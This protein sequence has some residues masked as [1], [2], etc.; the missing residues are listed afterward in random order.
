[1]STKGERKMLSKEDIRGILEKKRRAG[2]KATRDAESTEFNQ[3]EPCPKQHPPTGIKPS[4]PSSSVP[5]KKTEDS[6]SMDTVTAMFKMVQEM[7]SQTLL[8]QTIINE[9][10]DEKEKSL[11]NQKG[12]TEQNGELHYL[13]QH[14]APMESSKGQLRSKLLS[15]YDLPEAWPAYEW[16]KEWAGAQQ[17]VGALLAL[18]DLQSN[19]TLKEAIRNLKSN[20]KRLNRSL[21]PNEWRIIQPFIDGID[22][23]HEHDVWEICLT[24]DGTCEPHIASWLYACRTVKPALIRNTADWGKMVSGGLW[25]HITTGGQNV[26]KLLWEDRKSQWKP[27]PSKITTPKPPTTT[28]LKK[29]NP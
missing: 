5:E 29:T 27:T 16:P 18:K 25:P 26:G 11:S 1:M 8:Q 28:I 14:G 23:P 24:G 20:C 4:E 22:S 19:Y 3:S 13:I 21:F 6:M 9:L 10:R 12:S 7:H 17:V 2:E 15:G